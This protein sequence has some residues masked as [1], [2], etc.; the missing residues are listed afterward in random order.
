MKLRNILLTS[1]VAL[2]LST[3]VFASGDKFTPSPICCSQPFFLQIGVGYSFP[4]KSKLSLDKTFWDPAQEGYDSTLSDV[5]VFEAGLGYHIVPWLDASITTAY[6]GTYNYK[7]HQTALTGTTPG[8]CGTKTRYFDVDNYNVMFNLMWRGTGS[9]A[10]KFNN[11]MAIAPFIGGGIGM[12]R[13][14]VF[15]FH[16]ILGDTNESASIMEPYASY[17]LAAQGTAGL[18]WCLNSRTRLDLGYRFYY[19][20]EYKTNDY[21][22]D[23]LGGAVKPTTPTGRGIISPP[24]KADL[25]TNEGFLSL[26]YDI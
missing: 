20:G 22:G 25:M 17:S 3:A 12:A 6:R 9:L 24:W 19:G 1:L 2:V 18:T 5:P 7:Q 8:F 26:S 16:S 23:V 15:N 11:N 4:L 21:L 10:Y 13:N 14:N